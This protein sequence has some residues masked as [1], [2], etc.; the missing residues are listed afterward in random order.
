M[1]KLFSILFYPV[2]A[3]MKKRKIE[4]SFI[5]ENFQSE[6]GKRLFKLLK[7]YPITSPEWETSKVMGCDLKAKWKGSDFSIDVNMPGRDYYGSILILPGDPGL[8][9][10]EHNI[11]AFELFR[12][13]W[14]ILIEWDR[15]E[16]SKYLDKIPNP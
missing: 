16:R 4:R 8:P 2:T 1:K 6:A 10:N 5:E 14:P 11:L 12:Q 9:C 13:A 3:W 7:K 15:Q